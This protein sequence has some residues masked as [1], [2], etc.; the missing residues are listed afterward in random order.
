MK[1]MLARL[2]R[3]RE[4]ARLVVQ[5]ECLTMRRRALRVIVPA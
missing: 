1:D 5:L 3:R 4:R 2:D